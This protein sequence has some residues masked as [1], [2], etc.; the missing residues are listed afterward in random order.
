[1]FSHPYYSAEALGAE[2]A[3]RDLF[4]S[5]ELGRLSLLM[6]FGVETGGLEY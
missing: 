6:V 2:S 1:M 3:V 4:I 5:W